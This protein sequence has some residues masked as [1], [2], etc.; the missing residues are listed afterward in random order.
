MTQ[1]MSARSVVS[2]FVILDSTFN[3]LFCDFE[4]ILSC[5]YGRKAH[6]HQKSLHLRFT[7]TSPS[8]P[9]PFYTLAHCARYYHKLC[10]CFKERGGRKREGEREKKKETC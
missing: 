4:S 9:L 6:K 7:L 8:V 10:Y 1:I 3:L 2:K 5:G